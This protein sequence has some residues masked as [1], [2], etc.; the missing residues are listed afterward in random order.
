MQP[1][2]RVLYNTRQERLARDKHSSLFGLLNC[3]MKMK[4]CDFI[5]MGLYYKTLRVRNLW[6][7]DKFGSKLASFG[8]DKHTSLDK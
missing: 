6:E 3:Y 7:N 2:A 4:C 1:E 5:P 8:L